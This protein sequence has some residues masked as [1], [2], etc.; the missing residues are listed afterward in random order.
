M[1]NLCSVG[2]RV[3]S[4][5]SCRR[6]FIFLVMTGKGKEGR[7]KMGVTLTFKQQPDRGGQ[8]E[9]LRFL[10]SVES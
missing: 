8:A 7:V 2:M 9:E 5:D 6:N 3:H 4:G 10:P 1:R